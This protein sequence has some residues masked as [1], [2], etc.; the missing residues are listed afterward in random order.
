MT[1]FSLSQLLLV[2]TG[3]FLGSVGRYLVGV[4]AYRLVPIQVFP[5]GTLVVNIVGCF[6]IGVMGRM[7]ELQGSPDPSLR[8]FV[9]VGL[10]GGFTTF[11]AFAAESVGLAQAGHPGR[12]ALNVALQVVVGLAAA[13]AGY[14]LME[15]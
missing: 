12:A 2:G 4:L 1:G 15:G 13:W 8:L 9:L 11:S 14:Q 5:L 7:V 6:G 3:G 10:L